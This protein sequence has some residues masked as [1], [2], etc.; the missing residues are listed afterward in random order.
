MINLIDNMAL[1]TARAAQ[2][3]C[4]VIAVL[5]NVILCHRSDNTYIT[6]RV[7]IHA[8]G[9]EFISGCYDMDKD[10]GQS[11]LIERAWSIHL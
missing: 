5:E 2:L 8:Q 11:N 9:A 10:G 6:W 3:N 1:V 4:T 7:G